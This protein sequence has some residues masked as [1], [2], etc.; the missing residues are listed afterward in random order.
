[1]AFTRLPR[2]L[3]WFARIGFLAF[4]CLFIASSQPAESMTYLRHRGAIISIAWSEDGSLIATSSDF[5]RLIT[6][7]SAEGRLL[8][9]IRRPTGSCG[10]QDGPLAFDPDSRLLYTARDTTSESPKIAL[11][12]LDWQAGRWIRNLPSLP[13]PAGYDDSTYWVCGHTFRISPDNNSVAYL[14]G[15]SDYFALQSL[16]DDTALRPPLNEFGIVDFRWSPRRSEMALINISG[17]IEVKSIPDLSTLL[18]LRAFK[19]GSKVSYSS[20]GRLLAAAVGPKMVGGDAQGVQ[21]FGPVLYDTA[22]FVVIDRDK[23]N[24]VLSYQIPL[25]PDNFGIQDLAFLP[26]TDLVIATPKKVYVKPLAESAPFVELYSCESLCWIM[27]VS[28]N[29]QTLA[30]SDGANVVLLN[31]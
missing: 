9:E 18:S 20:D 30:V 23:N 15:K 7:W 17:T 21:R 2:R 27:S 4:A 6:V 5:D 24:A 11:S 13:L 3:H 29:S 26:S 16:R 28:P 25:L 22:S 14:Y 19:E 10:V 31:L 8:K 1:M 12:V